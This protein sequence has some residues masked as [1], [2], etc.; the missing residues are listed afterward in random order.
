MRRPSTAA[1]V[2]ELAQPDART[3]S[4]ADARAEHRAKLRAVPVRVVPSGEATRRG[5][6]ADGDRAVRSQLGRLEKNVLGA[7]EYVSS[8]VVTRL[9]P[10]AQHLL[11]TLDG[12]A[13]CAHTKQKFG[14]FGNFS[15]LHGDGGAVAV[16][17]VCLK[18]IS[19]L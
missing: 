2:A 10:A 7:C 18:L 11:V 15:S 1:S 6:A 3:G 14:H 17:L 12:L 8:V 5:L 19:G 4:C 9:I 13:A 16:L